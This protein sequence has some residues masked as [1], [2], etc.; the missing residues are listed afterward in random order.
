MVS[1]AL[2]GVESIW[3]RKEPSIHVSELAC[4]LIEGYINGGNLMGDTLWPE[5]LVKFGKGAVGKDDYLR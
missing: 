5:E 3:G 2:K 4:A 1:S